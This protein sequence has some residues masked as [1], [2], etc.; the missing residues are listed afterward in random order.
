MVTESNGTL[1]LKNRLNIGT[2]ISRAKVGIGYLETVDSVH[3]REVFNANDNFI[4]Y[5]DGHLKAK[6]GEFSGTVEIT[7]GTILGRPVSAF[8]G[9]IA[10]TASIISDNGYVFYDETPSSIT[11]TALDA[12]LCT[13][14]KNGVTLGT[15]STS[16]TIQNSEL[17]MGEMMTITVTTNDNKYASFKIYKTQSVVAELS[18]NGGTW[19]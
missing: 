2:D 3:Q 10:Q 5:E 1:W 8:G 7:G 17:M 9:M 6:S 15:T 12:T 14:T 13:W 4:V 11:V 18:L 16:L 19:D